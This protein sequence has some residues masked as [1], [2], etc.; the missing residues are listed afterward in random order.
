MFDGW[1]RRRRMSKVE[2]GD[3]SPLKPFRWWH[4][5]H[6]S[7]FL[8]PTEL[9]HA[10]GTDPHPTVAEAERTGFVVDVDHLDAK[11]SLY[12]DGRQ[13]G[14]AEPPVLF[15]VPGGVIDVQTT[16]YGMRRAHLVLDSGDERQLVPHPATAEAWRARLAER[17]PTVHRSLGA[18]A[19][20]VLLVALVL[21]VP[22]LAEYVTRADAVSEL[23]GTFTSPVTL[24]AWANTG[25]LVAG[26]LAGIERALTMR[27]HWLVDLETTWFGD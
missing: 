6:R 27:H 11:A 21:G 17:H 13:T 15:P 26:V 22:Q 12:A 10:A 7:R 18:A 8:L 23:V 20:V 19:V 3:D 1:R 9:L 24:P 5:L 2:S 25:L 4:A 14:F 16:S